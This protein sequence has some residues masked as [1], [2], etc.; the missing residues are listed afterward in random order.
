MHEENKDGAFL[1]SWEDFLKI[2]NNIS[3]CKKFP[4]SYE[5]QRFFGE[6]TE[7]NSGGTPTSGDP[8]ALKNYLKNP[9]YIIELKETTS[10]YVSLSQKDGRMKAKGSTNFPYEGISYYLSLCVF[11]LDRN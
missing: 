2:W 4:R 9:Q 11:S 6:W 7:E 3:M 8:A 5:A 10:L 1:M